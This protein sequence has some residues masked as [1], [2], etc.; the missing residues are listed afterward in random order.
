MN[1]SQPLGRTL[2]INVDPGKGT[3]LVPFTSAL[4]VYCQN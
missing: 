2:F 4:P 1:M 3:F